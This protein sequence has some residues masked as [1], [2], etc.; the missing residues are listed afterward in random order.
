MQRPKYGFPKPGSQEQSMIPQSLPFQPFPILSQFQDLRHKNRPP[1]R[2]M[3]GDRVRSE[4]CRKD[5]TA[6][7]TP[8][9][10]VCVLKGLSRSLES[11]VT[12]AAYSWVPKGPFE[13]VSRHTL[14]PP[15][16]PPELDP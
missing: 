12:T 15:S 1:W 7:F 3:E 9:S 4:R 8:I 5:A 2:S 11:L 13:S 16:C 6:A 10:E 14:S